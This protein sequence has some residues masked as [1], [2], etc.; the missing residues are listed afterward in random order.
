MKTTR[1]KPPSRRR[2][3]GP[4]RAAPKPRSTPARRPREPVSPDAVKLV[5]TKGTPGRGGDKG[6]QAWR[7]EVDGKRAGVVFINWIDEP[8]VGSHASIQIYLNLASQG[9]HIGRIAY[10][11]ACKASGYDEIY[12][13]M[14]KS[15]VASRR[16]AEEA[17][18]QEDARGVPQLLM[19]WRRASPP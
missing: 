16:A 10:A 8:P 4:K 14:R 12:A 1:S 7:I 18:F 15:N 19:V 17:G 9:R 5:P 13:H 2:R 3:A 11:A 6:G